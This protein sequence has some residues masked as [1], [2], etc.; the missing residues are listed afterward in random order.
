MQFID[1]VVE[2][3]VIVQCSCDQAEASFSS[4]SFTERTDEFP[5]IHCIELS[6][7]SVDEVAS[8]RSE[9]A[10]GTVECGEFVH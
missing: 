5:Q 9:E 10:R 2:V 4:S 8:T 1:K 6:G 3:P 7:G